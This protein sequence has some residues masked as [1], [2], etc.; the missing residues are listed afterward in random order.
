MLLLCFATRFFL[1]LGFVFPVVLQVIDALV[2]H[3]MTFTTETRDLPVLWHQSLLV[4]AQRYRGDIT[5]AD[6][7]RLKEV[8]WLLLVMVALMLSLVV[9]LFLFLVFVVVVVV[10]VV[11]DS[12]V[13]CPVVGG[14]DVVA[15]V[16]VVVVIVVVVGGGGGD[17]GDGSGGGLAM[18]VLM[19]WYRRLKVAL[20]TKCSKYEAGLQ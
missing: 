13:D 8:C 4:F 16:V 6:K 15:V 1:A 14:G 7:D 18:Y 3:F 9:V 19:G 10:V 2:D 20:P 5:R 17:D 11:V 12:P